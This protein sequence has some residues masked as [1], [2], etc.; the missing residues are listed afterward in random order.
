MP[1]AA[2]YV[3]QHIKAE[4]ELAVILFQCRTQHFMWCNKIYGS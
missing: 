4:A 2:F 1:H 3:V